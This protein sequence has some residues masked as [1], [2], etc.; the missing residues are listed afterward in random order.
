MKSTYPIENNTNPLSISVNVSSTADAVTVVLHSADGASW[1]NFPF[2]QID[3][4][5][6]ESVMGKANALKGQTI[7]ISVVL[8]F[9]KIAKANRKDAMTQTTIRYTLKGGTGG[10]AN[11]Q[12]DTDD[13]QKSSSGRTAWVR[14]QILLA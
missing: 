3:G 10:D 7:M 13:W 6:P 2:T 14:K 5:V 12:P 9:S 8:D 4:N 11:L 1:Q